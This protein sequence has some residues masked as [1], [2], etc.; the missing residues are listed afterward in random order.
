MIKYLFRVLKKRFLGKVFVKKGENW[1]SDPQYFCK[2]QE[3]MA[4]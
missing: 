4:V 2:C 3:G 1:N